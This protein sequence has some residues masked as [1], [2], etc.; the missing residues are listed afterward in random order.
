METDKVQV[1]EKCAAHKAK[2]AQVEDVEDEP[3]KPKPNSGRTNTQFEQA[4]AVIGPQLVAAQM[5]R[6]KKRNRGSK[7]KR[8]IGKPTGFEEWCTDGPM[9]PSE[10]SENRLIYHPD[11]SFLDRLEEA[12]MRFQRKR[13]IEPARSNVFHKYLQYGGVSV[14]P[15][16]GTGVTPKDMKEMNAEEIMQARTQ[17]LIEKERESL[18]ISF[19]QVVRGFLGSFFM[20]YFNPD[21]VE[22]IQLATGTIRNF[23][24]F[25]LFHDVCPE[26]KDDILQARKTCTIASLELWKNLQL[27]RKAPGDFNE[28]C[29]TLFG[30]HYFES[31]DNSSWATS[32]MSSEKAQLIVKYAIAGAGVHETASSFC[33]HVEAGTLSAERVQDID[34]FEV[35]SVAQPDY[36]TCD[37]YREF[38]FHMKLNPVGVVKAKSFREPGKPKID[39]SPKERWEWEHGNAPSYDF[40]FFVEK[41]LLDLLYPRLK[42]V[43]SIW[44]MNCGAYYFDQVYSTFPSFNISIANDMML[45]WKRP[46]DLRDEVQTSTE[47]KGGLFVEMDDT[48]ND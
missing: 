12:F 10:Y 2:H 22:S 5:Q 3:P 18:H 41:S 30:G 25:L 47:P 4:S 45:N 42:V 33:Q 26:Y 1:S 37:F 7:S 28:A 48:D 31:S 34:G 16:F 13:R 43:A 40:I 9:T 36:T 38:T 24:T 14:G 19:D 17:T 11:R 20:T 44:K 8:G 23:L 39:L 32:S 6:K 15:N 21:S 29:S 27:I 46:R 35:I